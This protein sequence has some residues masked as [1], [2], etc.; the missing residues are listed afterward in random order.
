MSPGV[1]PYR[2]KPAM[3]DFAVQNNLIVT[4]RTCIHRTV[5]VPYGLGFEQAYAEITPQNQTVTFY[6]RRKTMEL[7]DRIE[8]RIDFS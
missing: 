8:S 6:I 7:E 5:D 2:L 3:N 1:D 4:C